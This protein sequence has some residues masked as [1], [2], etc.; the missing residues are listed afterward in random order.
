MADVYEAEV[1]AYQK[2]YIEWQEAR[3]R[4]IG[5]AEG[6]IGSIHEELGWSFVDKNNPTEFF[7]RIIT[8][9]I[10]QLIICLVYLFLILVFIKRLDRI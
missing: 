9:W 2:E 7:P 10:A 6:L 5:E 8:T 3:S 1:K 4:A